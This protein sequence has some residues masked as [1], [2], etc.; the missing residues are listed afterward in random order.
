MTL[1]DTDYTKLSPEDDAKQKS[2]QHKEIVNKQGKLKIR[3]PIPLCNYPKAVRHFDS[4]FPNNYLDTVELKSDEKRLNMLVESFQDLI[5]LES[6]KER[7]ILN[8]I[9]KEK[10]YFIIASILK[11]YF[12]F[13]HH[14]AYLFREFQLGNGSIPFW[15]ID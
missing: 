7:E 2:L 14:G 10:A 5:N 13:G 12:N 3:R 15:K 8:F 9:Y 4:L 11:K 6:A 1:Y